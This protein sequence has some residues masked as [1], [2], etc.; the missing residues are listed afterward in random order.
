MVDGVEGVDVGGPAEDALPEH[1]RH[2]QPIAGQEEVVGLV[3]EKR[4]VHHLG[5]GQG[6]GL[7]RV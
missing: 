3:E 7:F 1:E 4:S 5:K 2:H 6:P